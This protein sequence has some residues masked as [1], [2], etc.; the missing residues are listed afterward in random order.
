MLKERQCAKMTPGANH[1]SSIIVT[2]HLSPCNFVS[3]GKV[4]LDR[5]RFPNQVIP[6][7]NTDHLPDLPI[8]SSTISNNIVSRPLTGH[9]QCGM[10]SILLRIAIMQPFLNAS[11][12]PREQVQIVCEISCYERCSP[13]LYVRMGADWRARKAA[14][15]LALKGPEI[16]EG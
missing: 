2:H 12:N 13:P 16:I 6:P 3:G 5:A 10:I 11:C 15:S 4:T 1:R 9:Y 7:R 8:V 14:G